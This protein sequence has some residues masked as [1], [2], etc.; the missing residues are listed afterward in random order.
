MNISD[1]IEKI[2]KLLNTTTSLDEIEIEIRFGKMVRGIYEAEVDRQFYIQL[3]EY[4]DKYL[5]DGKYTHS[6]DKYYS[7]GIRYT[8][9]LQ[10]GI[11]TH[12]GI[13]Y[14]TIKTPIF[15]ETLSDGIIR[16]SVAKENIS[17]E[18][19]LPQNNPITIR[20]KKRYSYNFQ[21]MNGGTFR[22][23]C[24]EVTT[25]RTIYEVEIEIIQLDIP[26]APNKLES[27]Q[28]L[29]DVIEV[30]F[31][32]L[33]GTS[34]LFS[35]K[36]RTDVI[37]NINKYLG[38]NIS[39]TRID[40]KFLAQARNIKAKDLV[41]GELIVGT[42]PSVTDFVSYTVTDKANGKRKFLVIDPNGIYL[43]FPPVF[44][45]K[46]AT[47]KDIES[48]KIT[49]Y[50]GTIVEGEYIN[51]EELINSEHKPL[52]LLYD[53]VSY[54]GNNNI[55]KETLEKR[56]LYLKNVYDALK[57][58]QHLFPM[59][60]I[61]MKEFIPFKTRDEFYSA[62][63][64]VLSKS[65][66]YHIDGL[67]FTPNNFGYSTDL[68]NKDP[69]FRKL[70]ET[71]DI[72]KWKFSEELTIDLAVV[73]TPTEDG[74]NIVLYAGNDSDSFTQFVGD[75]RHPFKLSTDLE[76]NQL[77]RS[78]PSHSI[79]EFGWNYK[80]NKLYAKKLRSNKTLPNKIKIVLDVWNDIHTPISKNLIQGNEIGLQYRYHNRIKTRLY[81]MLKINTEKGTK[82][83]L[84][85][86]A[87]KGG[88]V[89]KWVDA[90]FT[91]V[92]CVEPNPIFII[93]LQ[94]RLET[95]NLNFLIIQTIGQE[96]NL[97]IK[98]LNEFIPGGKVDVVAYMLSLSFF[99]DT[100]ESTKS[101]IELTQQTL[102]SGGYFIALSIDK[103][104]V[105]E[106]L[107]TS[108]KSFE[109]ITFE[110]DETSQQLFINI[111]GS[112]VQNQTEWL[113]D[114]DYLKTTFKNLG[115]KLIGEGRADK[116]SFLNNDELILSKMYSYFILMK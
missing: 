63:N 50:Y 22:L 92:V 16:I 67:I 98:E 88:D 113:A 24:T 73:H 81:Q 28:T 77:L 100:P 20:D 78:V 1:A 12:P 40:H 114:L 65:Y 82:T 26:G 101:V 66:P 71:P 75:K 34:L 76:I 91:H 99:F 14:K 106:Y 79:V 85:I 80:T 6:L 60:E 36:E 31:Q 7:D 29:Y 103:K 62:V 44:L 94:K 72:L 83:M 35:Q 104:Y 102:K 105:M 69:R 84:N 56:H 25:N 93:E 90:G 4:A 68:Y 17:E 109:T 41:G 48:Y 5:A 59:F 54:A 3:K 61:K 11:T 10:N 33:Y 46:I 21:G 51:E 15:K 115:Y 43:M 107:T 64:K 27:L 45:D 112:I 37:K 108:Q 95:T 97:I 57:I 86:G 30:M 58:R 9:Y 2:Q 38:T 53:I 111:P 19:S 18:T 13:Y 89:Q 32:K 23:D 116:E 87:G 42:D 74:Q 110:F 39:E 55:Q 47:T 96:T 70:S 52:F 8:V 49:K